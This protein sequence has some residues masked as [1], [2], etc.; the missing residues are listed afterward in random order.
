MK[1]PGTQQQHQ[2]GLYEVPD[3]YIPHFER[4]RFSQTRTLRWGY[5]YLSYVLFILEKLESLTF[6]SLLDV[7]CGDGRFLHEVRRRFGGVHLSG[8]DTSDRAIRYARAFNP[9]IEF[10]AADITDGEPIARRYD[11]I[12]MVDTLEHIAPERIAAFLAAARRRLNDDGL[13]IITVPSTNIDLS[14]KHHQHFDPDSLASVLDPYFTITETFHLNRKSWRVRLLHRLL[15]NSLF[16]LNQKRLVNVLF[17][18]YRRRFLLA[19]P[20]DGGRICAICGP[21]RGA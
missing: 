19:G 14:R 16:I 5:E 8:I 15:S 7:G 10:F 9:D 21:N 1:P 4:G 3:H 12:V 2:E 17:R 11:V 20:A 18:H 13:L 6:E